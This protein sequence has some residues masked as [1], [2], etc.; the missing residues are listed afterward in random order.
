[1]TVTTVTLL[2]VTVIVPRTLSETY[3]ARLVALM[4]RE[5]QGRRK[6]KIKK[7][8]EKEGVCVYWH[9]ETNLLSHR[10]KN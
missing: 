1:M 2:K 7:E 6:G 9:P 3:R 10:Y 5:R 4:N 8:R